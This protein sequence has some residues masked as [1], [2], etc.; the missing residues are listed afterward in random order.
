[1]HRLT[2]SFYERLGGDEGALAGKR[3]GSSPRPD[4]TLAS[5]A[6]IVEVDEIQHFT[7][8]RLATLELHLADVRLAFDVGEYKVLARQWSSIADRYRAAKTAVDFPFS[9]GRRRAAS[10]FRR[11]T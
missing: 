9:G 8:D 10:V 1:M 2:R 11:R 5:A 4:F 6:L 3:A 7:S